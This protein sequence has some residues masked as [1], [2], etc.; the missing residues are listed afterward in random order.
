MG[1]SSKTVV[2]GVRASQSFWEKCDK[3]AVC[4]NITR[5]ELILRVMKE[6]I[7]NKCLWV[8]EK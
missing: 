6:Y 1:K 3:V 2:R 8:S 5:N 4:E 7:E